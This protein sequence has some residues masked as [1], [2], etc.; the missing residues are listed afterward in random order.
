MR[1][2]LPLQQ[3]LGD[4]GD[5][6]DGFLDCGRIGRNFRGLGGGQVIADGIGNDE[7]AVGQALHEGAGAEAVGA[8][9]GEVGFA[10][11][12][13]ARESWTSNCSP[14]RGRPWCSGWRDRCA[15]GTS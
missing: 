11:N 3:L 8:V 5:V 1:L 7:V 14:P 6:G 10:E 2:P 4:G 12:E 15:S 9:I 13:Q